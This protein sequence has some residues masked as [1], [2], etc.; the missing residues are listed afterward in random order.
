[1][2]KDVNLKELLSH[3]RSN[4]YEDFEVKTPHTGVISF[5]IKEGDQVKGPSGKWLHYPGTLLFYLEREKNKKPVYAEH[6]GEIAALRKRING[7]FVE[8]GETVLT[9]R[10]KLNKEEI[11][12]KILT[13]VLTIFPA[14]QRARYFLVPDI[15]SK[16]EAHKANLPIANGDE[17]VIMSLMKRD[18]L[19]P[20]NKDSGI[21]Y[22]VYFHQGEMVEQGSP[23]LGICPPDKVDYVQKVVERIR[24][25]WEEL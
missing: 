25:Q 18:T 23:L 3:Y 21:I 9:I 4:P 5:Q 8:A 12:D 10:H 7:A 2:T 15:A 16:L 19:I 13:K 1:M 6:S 11:I 17:V 20:Y 14:P 24:T 22:K